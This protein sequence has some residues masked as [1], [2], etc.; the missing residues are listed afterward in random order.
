MSYCM[1]S[2]DREEKVPCMH[3]LLLLFVD[4]MKCLCK[5]HGLNFVN[6]LDQGWQFDIYTYKSVHLFIYLFIFAF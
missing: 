6:E 4:N 3:Q 2:A 5:E 1:Q